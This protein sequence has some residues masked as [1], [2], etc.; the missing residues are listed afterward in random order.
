[1]SRR[2]S[3]LRTAWKPRLQLAVRTL[4]T[5][6]NGYVH[7]CYFAVRL[8][9]A[10]YRNRYQIPDSQALTIQLLGKDDLTLDDAYGSEAKMHASWVASY[11]LTAAT[12]GVGAHV[13]APLLK[14]YVLSVIL[15]VSHLEL[16]AD[17][18]PFIP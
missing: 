2:A 12:E 11:A 1:M 15:L 17:A 13:K 10:H 16:V 7:P 14:R 4:S 9:F 6:S 18:A 8:R 5:A 3:R